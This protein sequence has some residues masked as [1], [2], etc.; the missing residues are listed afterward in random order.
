MAVRPLYVPL[1]LIVL[2][3]NRS[4]LQ[5]IGL[6]SERNP[7]FSNSIR[8]QSYEAEIYESK[9]TWHCP[10]CIS[11]RI[12]V[13]TIIRTAHRALHHQNGLGQENSTRRACFIW[14]GGL[15]WSGHA[16]SHTEEK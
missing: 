4:A 15:H 8:Q 9:L 5:Y 13:F 6:Q 1:P 16:P 12:P 10:I 2:R 11:H 14:I 3:S 7:V